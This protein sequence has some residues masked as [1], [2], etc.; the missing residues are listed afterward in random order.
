MLSVEKAIPARSPMDIL[1]GIMM[2]VNSKGVSFTANNLEFAVKAVIDAEMENPT[3]VKMIFPAKFIDIIKNLPGEE[4]DIKTE[5]NK[6]TITAGDSVFELNCIPG[7]EYPE[8]S[9]YT[10]EWQHVKFASAKLKE[11]INKCLFA[12][13]ADENKPAF[14]GVLF[15]MSL[16]ILTV[17]ASDTY[18]LVKIM[19]D[20]ETDESYRILIPGKSLQFFSRVIENEQDKNIDLYFS[21]GEMV[22]MFDN[23]TV[24]LRLLAD[25]F[26]DLSNVIPAKFETMIT[27]QGE[28]LKSLLNRAAIVAENNTVNIAVKENKLHISTSSE[29]MGHME[30]EMDIEKTGNDFK[31]CFNINY[32]R[33]ALKVT[34]ENIEIKFNGSLGPCVFKQGNWQYL[35][36]PIKMAG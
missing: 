20:T 30:E 7:E 9:H 16:G 5:D 2:E 32:L 10:P 19:D 18:R 4:I 1:K 27:V 35:A 34:K 15:E 8:L 3:D 6:A 14:K 23:Y 21:N 13:S 28:G 24:Y 11:I 17:I 25:K 22:A 31:A 33:D 12:T 29:K 36:L 26:P